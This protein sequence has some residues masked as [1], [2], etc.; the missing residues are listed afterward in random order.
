MRSRTTTHGWPQ[1]SATRRLDPADPYAP[2]RHI[3]VPTF[4]AGDDGMQSGTSPAA[5][6]V[7]MGWG[8]A[9]NTTYVVSQSIP[10]DAPTGIVNETTRQDPLA[11]LAR[12]A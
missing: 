5:L 1:W 11:V 4:A 9:A 2:W 6:C 12:N 10:E 3:G 7:G 8:R